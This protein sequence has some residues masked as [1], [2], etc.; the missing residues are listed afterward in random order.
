MDRASTLKAERAMTRH[1]ALL[2]LALLL[3]AVFAAPAWAQ[4]PAR[5]VRIVATSAPGTAPDLLARMV[6]GSLSQT[7]KQ[8]FIVENRSGAG[9][10]VAADAVAKSPSDGYTLLVSPDPVFVTNPYLYKNL[11]FDALKDLVPVSS[12]MS[13]QFAL[14]VSLSVPVKSLPEFIDYA[15]RAKAPVFY[16]TAGVGTASHL[17]MEMLKARAGV[18]LVHVPFDGGGGPLMSALMR[19]EVAATIGGTAALAQVK[20]GKLAALATTGASRSTHY[21]E[22]PTFAETL[23]GYEVLTWLGL[24]A[25]AGTPPDVIAR[26]NSEVSSFLALADTRQKFAGMGGIDAMISKPE[27]FAALIRR[28][29][30]KYGRI[31]RELGINLQ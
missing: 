13:Q 7:L 2:S 27:Q 14:C 19:G 8:T 28:D 20:A 10:N 1:R 3:C 12:I 18:N 24:F 22:L 31:I 6:A 30:E 26:L 17:A 29:N 4:Y 25:P 9:G 23:P 15:K 21:P 11:S 16:G 5:L